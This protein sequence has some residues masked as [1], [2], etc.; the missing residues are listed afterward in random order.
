MTSQLISTNLGF[1]EASQDPGFRTVP[2][3]RPHLASPSPPA[4]FG[5]GNFDPEPKRESAPGSR[6]DQLDTAR[7]LHYT[8]IINKISAGMIPEDLSVFKGSGEAGL[9]F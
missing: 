2:P 3:G 9:P 7:Q 8:H 6:S 4:Q 1:H 5:L